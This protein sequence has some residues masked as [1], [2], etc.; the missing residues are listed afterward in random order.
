M[1]SICK[2]FVNTSPGPPNCPQPPSF[3]LHAGTIRPESRELPYIPAKAQRYSTRSRGRRFYRIQPRKPAAARRGGT[4]RP[5][6]AKESRPRPQ[7]RLPSE[8]SPASRRSPAS[9]VGALRVIS[10]TLA[11]PHNV[12]SRAVLKAGWPCW[13]G[14]HIGGSGARP[15]SSLG[16]ATN[17]D[18]VASAG[19]WLPAASQL[20]RFSRT[21]GCAPG[22][23]EWSRSFADWCR[24]VV[25]YGAHGYQV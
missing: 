11:N 10:A 16:S 19:A 17:C 2:H 5:P 13:L 4:C 9:H 20:G 22:F 6:P 8:P 15:I 7:R 12:R 21:A 1:S 24:H 25:L 14:V 3:R 18:R 23:A